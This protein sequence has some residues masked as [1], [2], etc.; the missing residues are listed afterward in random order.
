MET[1]NVDNL[2][3]DPENVDILQWK[4]TMWILSLND[5][6]SDN[7]TVE[8]QNVEMITIVIMSI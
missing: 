3:M 6:D 8:T 5:N 2:T 7:L 1:D 4:H